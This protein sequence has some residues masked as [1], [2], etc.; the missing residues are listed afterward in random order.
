MDQRALRNIALLP[1]DSARKLQELQVARAIAEDASGAI[2]GRLSEL[3]DADGGLRD[4]LLAERDKQGKKHAE[5][6]RLYNRMMQWLAELPAGVA[7]EAMPQI[8]IA[9]QPGEKLIDAIESARGEIAALRQQRDTTKRA[10]LSRDDLDEAA[11]R[12]VVQL[13]RQGRPQIGVVADK[14]RVNFRGDLFAPEDTLALLAWATPELL[15]RAV[16][17]EIERLPVSASALSAADRVARVAELEAQLFEAERREQR[18][19][20]LAQA[21]G[22]DLLPRADASVPV[23]LGVRIA[24]AVHAVA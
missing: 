22:L 20:D 21:D 9:L 7:L 18:L 24:T 4:R 13:A 5:L 12:Y 17:R 16:M 6:N 19:L 14:L 1:P 11:E 2:T 10:S 15:Y 23:L 3:R 8:D